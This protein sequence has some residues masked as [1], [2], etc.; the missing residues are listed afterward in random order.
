MLQITNDVA[1]A[2]AGEHSYCHLVK[3]ELAND[4]TIRLTDSG[5]DIDLNGELY[6][7]N[8]LLLGMDAPTFNAEL[9]IGEI[10]LAFTAADQSVVALMLGVNQINRY[11]H[12]YRAY[13]NDQGQVI[14][15]PI[16]LHS[17][18]INAPDV[19]DSKDD[20]QITVPLTSEWADFEA[21]RGRRSTDANQ[22]RFFPTDKGLEFASQVKKDLKWGGE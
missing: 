11:A 13:L 1:A 2:L 12:I 16:L 9:R 21:P 8:G 14:P 22:R 15:N 6:E 10:S 17:W 5:I 3:L 4:V 7:H 20:S 18:L 19:S